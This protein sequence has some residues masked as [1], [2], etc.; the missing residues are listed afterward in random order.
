[1][2]KIKKYFEGCTG[3][4]LFGADGYIDEVW[5]LI[6]AR[7]SVG[8]YTINGTM[9]RFGQNIIET[10]TGGMANEIV[11]KRR[12]FGGFCANTG[13]AAARLGLD[14]VLLGMFGQPADPVF[15]EPFEKNARLISVGNPA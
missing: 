10:G 14:P 15:A 1:M 6:E 4:I 5:Q 9:K 2:D 13:N 11:R 3:K 8:E 12:C 7:V